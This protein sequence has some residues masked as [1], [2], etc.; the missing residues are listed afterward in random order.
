MSNLVAPFVFLGYVALAVRV[1]IATRR[2]RGRPPRAVHLLLLYT[3]GVTFG[4]AIVHRDFWPF[5][6]WRMMP[7]IAPA[8]VGDTAV[9]RSISRVRVMGVTADGRE[10]W[11]DPRA[12]EPLN[13]AEL[14]AWLAHRFP[15]LRA[16]ERARAGAWLLRAAEAGRAATRAGGEPGY[17][18]RVFGPLTAPGHYLY[19]RLWRSPDD[20]PAEPFRLV[21]V[22]REVWDISGRERDP[23]ALR[24]ERVYEYPTP[25]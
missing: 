19:A 12:W 8:G 20:V 23:A 15:I 6:P 13:D 16:T 2:R 25:P 24:L 7:R 10:Y 14:G 17:L 1:A 3:L 4:V 11:V 22:Y 9:A 21:R 5:S 18:D